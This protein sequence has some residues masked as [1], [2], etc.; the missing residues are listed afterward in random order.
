MCLYALTAKL[1]L[2]RLLSLS[3]FQIQHVE[4]AIISSHAISHVPAVRRQSGECAL[5]NFVL[6][7]KS[8]ATF[9]AKIILVFTG[10]NGEAMVKVT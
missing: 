2:L 7:N 1:H 10:A 3:E 9:L 6:L 4:A 5:W 8:S